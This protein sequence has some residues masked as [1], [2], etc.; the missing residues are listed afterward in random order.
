MPALFSLLVLDPKLRKLRLACALLIY[1][2]IL[3]GGSIPGARAEIGEYA[4][5]GVLHSFAYALLAFLWFMGSSGSPAARALK[6]MLAVALMG[7]GDEL[8]QSYF[9]YRTGAVGDWMVDC[10]AG[11]VTSS[12]L[13][14]LHRLPATAKR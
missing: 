14:A 6:S 1:L 8:V 2:A 13:W 4:S 9:P 11:I 10:A 5:G 12:L 3:V 7:A